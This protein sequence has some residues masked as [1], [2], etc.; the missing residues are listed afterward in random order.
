MLSVTYLLPITFM[1]LIWYS[2]RKNRRRGRLGEGFQ[3]AGKIRWEA[4]SAE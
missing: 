4:E 2:Y 1:G 3:P